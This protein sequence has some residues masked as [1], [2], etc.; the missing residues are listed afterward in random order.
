MI[1]I[2]L[3]VLALVAGGIA[4]ELFS[5]VWAPQD[6]KDQRGFQLAFEAYHHC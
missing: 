4:L 2:A 5:A 3:V 6:E 1:D